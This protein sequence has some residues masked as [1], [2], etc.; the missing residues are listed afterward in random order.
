MINLN[1][2]KAYR[3][4]ILVPYINIILVIM[5]GSYLVS[6]RQD[7]SIVPNKDDACV[8]SNLTYTSGGFRLSFFYNNNKQLVAKTRTVYG[9]LSITAP[10]FS[11]L[12]LDTVIYEN[13]KVTVYSLDV[14]GGY[15]SVNIPIHEPLEKHFEKIVAD[16]S[17]GKVATI[18]Y[19]TVSRGVDYFRFRKEI[20]FNDN[21]IRKIK[22]VGNHDICGGRSSSLTQIQIDYTYTYLNTDTATVLGVIKN[23]D[24][25]IFGNDTLGISFHPLKN[26]VNRPDNLPL[27]YSN[28]IFEQMAKNENRRYV[29]KYSDGTI[30]CYGES[31]L[32]VGRY[33]DNGKGYPEE[34]GVYKCD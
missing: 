34:L 29:Y 7:K 30:A 32:S 9:R 20:E 21:Q 26:P 18:N 22:I 23:T 4:R 14:T 25:I 12:V 3:Y 33:K 10:Q 27:F 16:Y 6:C 24:G 13:N 8:L 17:N 2:I 15:D 5:L 28:F 19:Y 11:S 31:F 1:E